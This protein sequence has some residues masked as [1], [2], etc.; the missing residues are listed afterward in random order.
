[1]YKAAQRNG[2][3]LHTATDM[4]SWSKL[5]VE[6]QKQTKQIFKDGEKKGSIGRTKSRVSKGFLEILYSSVANLVVIWIQVKQKYYFFMVLKGK[7]HEIL[8][9]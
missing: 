3:Q 1:M 2:V 8:K 9:A 6:T 5:F 4:D 7:S